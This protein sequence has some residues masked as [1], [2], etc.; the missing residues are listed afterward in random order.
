MISRKLATLI[1]AILGGLG[2]TGIAF[3]TYFEPSNATIINGAISLGVST[4]IT[5]I[6]SFAKPAEIEKELKQ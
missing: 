5:I 1:S 2:T 6:E 3:V 4:A